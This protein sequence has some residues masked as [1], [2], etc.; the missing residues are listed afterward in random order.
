MQRSNHAELDMSATNNYQKLLS[1]SIRRLVPLTLMLSAGVAFLDAGP[2]SARE[3]VISD[4][5]DEV[6]VHAVPQVV[7]SLTLDGGKHA[8]NNRPSQDKDES[9]DDGPDDAL[10]SGRSRG[11]AIMDGS[12][13]VVHAKKAQ[14]A[15]DLV[16]LVVPDHDRHVSTTLKNGDDVVMLTV[17]RNGEDAIIYGT[18]WRGAGQAADHSRQKKA[19]IPV[20]MTFSSTLKLDGAVHP[21]TITIPGGM[22]INVAIL[23]GPGAASSEDENADD[24]IPS[25]STGEIGAVAGKAERAEEDDIPPPPPQSDGVHHSVMRTK[26]FR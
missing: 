3:L 2:A 24:A 6:R 11:D 12:D 22:S 16:T 17:S 8:R 20:G 19:V 15:N 9:D 13:V 25:H 5:S 26:G 23:A 1:N 18:I 14:Q 4:G 21:D 10:L 7:L